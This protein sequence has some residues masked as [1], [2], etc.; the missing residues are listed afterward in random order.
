MQGP[1]RDIEGKVTKIL[2]S[3][4]SVNIAEQGEYYV[5]YGVLDSRYV[6]K[7]ADILISVERN[8]KKRIFEAFPAAYGLNGGAGYEDYQYGIY[9]DKNVIGTKDCGL[10]VIA[11]R[12]GEYYSLQEISIY[13][14][15]KGE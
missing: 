1:E 9:L 2:Q 10:E 7:N 13:N 12:D 15:E 4:T 8:G 14:G 6:E 5:V 11:G 3:D